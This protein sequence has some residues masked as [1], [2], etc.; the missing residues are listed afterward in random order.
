MLY[1]IKGNDKDGPFEVYRRFSDFNT[2]RKAMVKR[3]PGVY[4]PPIPEK[5]AVG[6]MDSKFIEERRQLLEKFC[7]KVS[8]LPHLFYS[9]EFKVFLRS[10]NQDLE[11][12]VYIYINI[13]E[14]FVFWVG[15]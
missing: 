14:N 9:D 7:L 10:I 3:W 1:L 15:K 2:L 8:E 4:I 12:V 11:K 13:Y 5:K 6:N